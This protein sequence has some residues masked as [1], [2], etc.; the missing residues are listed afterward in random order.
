[1]PVSSGLEKYFDAQQK[2]RTMQNMKKRFADLEWKIDPAFMQ[3]FVS[4][5][6]KIMGIVNENPESSDMVM[7][8]VDELTKHI[9][10]TKWK[11]ELKKAEVIIK[12]SEKL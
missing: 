2:K 6:D 1:M 7:Q 11:Y 10:R 4:F 3:S 9:E 8:E 5:H 12:N